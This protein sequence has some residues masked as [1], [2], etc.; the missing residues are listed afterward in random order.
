MAAH[1]QMRIIGY[2]TN[3]PIIKGEEGMNTVMMNVRTTHRHTEDIYADR[4][5]ED[6]MV[7]FNDNSDRKLMGRMKTL[8]KM[9]LVDIKGVFSVM[10]LNKPSVCGL[11]GQQNIKYNGCL[12]VLWPISAIKRGN[13]DAD[14]QRWV[15]QCK[16][17]RELT[18]EEREAGIMKDPKPDEPIPEKVL[19]TH[20]REISNQVLVI[21]TLVSE[22]ERIG[23]QKRPGCRYMLGI[24][25]KYYIRTQSDITADY[26]YVYSYGEQALLDL[27]HLHKGSLVLVD[28]FLRVRDVKN[29]MVCEHCGAS[30]QFPDAAM[31]LI[32]FSV[33]YLNNYWTDEDIANFEDEK[34][35]MENARK[36]KEAMGV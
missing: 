2:V 14:Y 19:V 10:Q 13:L 35:A 9:D 32:P 27:R 26:P 8:K 36:A 31:E 28:A 24:D 30:Y 16:A 4:I 22:P 20:F 3:H 29:N 6:I 11:C 15:D 1:N 17:Y 33:E 34:T 7:Y 25:R 21:G 18:K 23:T 5:F 12:T